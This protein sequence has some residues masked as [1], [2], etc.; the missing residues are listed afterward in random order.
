MQ[1]EAGKTER[2]GKKQTCVDVQKDGGEEAEPVREK[3]QEH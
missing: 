3:Y 1:V 2:E